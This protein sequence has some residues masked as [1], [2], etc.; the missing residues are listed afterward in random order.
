MPDVRPDKRSLGSGSRLRSFKDLGRY[1]V[2]D[3]LLVSTLYDSFILSEDGQL[4]EVMLDEF[5]DLD[6][7]HT[8]RL[9]RVSTGDHAL[10]IA[11]DEGRYN[12]LISSMHVADMSAK[13]LAEKVEAAGLQTPVISLAYD[14][15]DL[16]DVDVSEVGTKVD[17]VFLWQGDVRILLAIVKYVEDRMNVARDTGEMGVQAIIVIEDNVRFYSSFL[18]VI[19]TEL[20]RHS[21][22]LLPDGMNRSHKLMRIQARP[23]IL[24][25]GTYEEAWRYFDAHQD[26]V[27]GVISDVSFRMYDF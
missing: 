14:I 9:R 13:T 4:S 2:N 15:R 11:R 23:K 7:H 16:S 21:H 18:P 8:P 27:L 12:L 3:I 6:L 26:D 22:S 17:R 19:Y 1:R 5:L 10:R 25:C 20:M 24:L